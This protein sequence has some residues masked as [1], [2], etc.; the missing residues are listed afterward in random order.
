MSI[1]SVVDVVLQEPIA[2]GSFICPLFKLVPVS[3]LSSLLEAARL[4]V[5]PFSSISWSVVSI[6]DGVLSE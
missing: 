2:G 6:A 5:L 4:V 3:A 1:Q